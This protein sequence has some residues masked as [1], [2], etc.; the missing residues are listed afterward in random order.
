[1]Q[2]AL[3]KR[4]NTAPAGNFGAPQARV[5]LGLAALQLISTSFGI[6]HGTQAPLR[7]PRLEQISFNRN[8]LNEN[9]CMKSEK[10]RVVAVWIER[11]TR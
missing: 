9:A 7:Q 4:H 8:R 10:I 6:T 2:N 1:M 11:E 3:V 5:L